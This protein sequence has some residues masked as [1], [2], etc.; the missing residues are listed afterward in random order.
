ML[1]IKK[2]VAPFWGN[3]EQQNNVTKGGQSKLIT[4][5]ELSTSK[6][7]LCPGFNIGQSGLL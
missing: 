1:S 4:T 2:T 6:V 7:K 5:T 3:P